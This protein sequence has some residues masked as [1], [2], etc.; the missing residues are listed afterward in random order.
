M[1]GRDLVLIELQGIDISQSLQI[2]V[3]VTDQLPV[4]RGTIPIRLLS[5][6]AQSAYARKRSYHY[7]SASYKY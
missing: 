5:A 1:R 7:L 4:T 2:F 3:L 6:L